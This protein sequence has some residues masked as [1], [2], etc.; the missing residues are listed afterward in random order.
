M[1]D[2]ITLAQKAKILTPAVRRL[3]QTIRQADGEARIVGGAVRDLITERA[4]GDIDLATTLPPESM[5][6][7]LAQNG[8]KVKPTGL[9]H[10]TV[11]AIID[12]TGY[13]I[14]TLRRD[15]E[16]DGRRAKVAF[17]DDWREDA[18]RR[19][20]TINSMFYN[21]DTRKKE[22]EL[23]EYTGLLKGNGIIFEFGGHPIQPDNPVHW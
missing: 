17:T 15:V 6:E 2:F 5:M 20:F 10:G 14:T 19:D 16:T 8:I 4:I 13:E 9:A 21:I 1:T 22:A 18:T 23:G 7:I 3:M 11:T 12:R